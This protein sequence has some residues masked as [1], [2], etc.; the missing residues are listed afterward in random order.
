MKVEWLVPVKVTIVAHVWVEKDI[1]QS[2]VETIAVDQVL[3]HSDD[4]AVDYEFLYAELEPTYPA[5]LA[6]PKSLTLREE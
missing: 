5:I 1:P 4:N 2:T 6:E 3:V